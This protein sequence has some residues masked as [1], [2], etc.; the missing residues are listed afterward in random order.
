MRMEWFQ[1]CLWLA[2]L[3]PYSEM[4]LL[5]RKYC[6]FLS[7]QVSFQSIITFSILLS[8]FLIPS[9]RFLLFFRILP[10]F[11][12]LFA[13]VFVIVFVIPFLI[14][15]FSF[16]FSFILFCFL[17]SHLFLADILDFLLILSLYPIMQ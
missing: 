17:P 9:I 4:V 3:F 2:K 11:I 7:F 1:K 14:L 12:L 10:F 16:L 13:L 6:G 5:I 15:P 8:L